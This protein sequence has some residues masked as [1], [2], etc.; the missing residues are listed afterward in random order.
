MSGLFSF[1][2]WKFIV[3][4][5]LSKLSNMVKKYHFWKYKKHFEL[6]S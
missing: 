3:V 5:E 2:I 4:E 1:H 6:L